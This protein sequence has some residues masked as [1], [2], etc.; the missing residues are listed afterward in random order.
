MILYPVKPQHSFHIDQRKSKTI[1]NRLIVTGRI[2]HPQ[3]Q[4]PNCVRRI[5]KLF[6]PSF[7][8]EV[9]IAHLSAPYLHFS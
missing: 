5:A 7:L 6:K 9:E 2:I 4:I 1:R 3:F 8:V